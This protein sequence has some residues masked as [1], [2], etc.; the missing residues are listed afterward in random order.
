MKMT[1]ENKLDKLPEILIF[2]LERFLDGAKKV[3]IHPDE[4]LE[5]QDYLD[6]NLT[7]IK[8]TY[9]W[10]ICYKHHFGSTK[11]HCQEICLIKINETWY[12]FNV[13]NT[14]LKIKDYDDCS[15]GLYYKRFSFHL[16]IFKFIYKYLLNKF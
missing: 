13:S 9:I 15:Y 3:Q 2:T 4:Y 7:G 10:V 16:K 6:P 1:E 12:E 11:Y 5:L 8:T 14:S